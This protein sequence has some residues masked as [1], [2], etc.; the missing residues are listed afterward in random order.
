MVNTYTIL[1]KIL[2]L[3]VTMKEKIE[4]YFPYYFHHASQLSMDA[5]KKYMRLF[6]WSLILLVTALLLSCFHSLFEKNKFLIVYS[7]II[8]LLIVS[9]TVCT[10]L[11]HT[12]HLQKKWYDGRAIAESIKTMSWKYINYAH[13]YDD[14][15]AEELFEGDIKT[16]LE[17]RKNIYQHLALSNEEETK[18][19]TDE[20]KDFK[21]LPFEERKE[22]YLK[23]RIKHQI[24]WYKNKARKNACDKKKWFYVALSFQLLAILATYILF[25]NSGLGINFVGLFATISTSLISWIQVKRYQEL[26]EAYSITA[27]ELNFIYNKSKEIDENN[28]SD[29]IG[30]AEKAISREHTLWIARRDQ[31]F[32]EDVIDS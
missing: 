7:V 14:S 15:N 3:E 1:M 20:M 22:L 30:D 8:A 2:L 16:I 12:S 23:Q 21:R 4:D 26:F 10:W 9:S 6:K 11:V 18:L 24:N 17:K 32:L 28:L 5:Q 29:F 27:G 13:P 19:I 31:S 25:W